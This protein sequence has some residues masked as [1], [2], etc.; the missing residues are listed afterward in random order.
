LIDEKEDGIGSDEEYAINPI[1]KFLIK[2]KSEERQESKKILKKGF[3][4]KK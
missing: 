2:D 1:I 4:L 3:T